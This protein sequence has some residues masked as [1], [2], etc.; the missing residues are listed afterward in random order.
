MLVYDTRVGGRG[1]CSCLPD[2]V[3]EGQELST[4]TRDGAR[5]RMWVEA[6]GGAR[7]VRKVVGVMWGL[8]R[9]GVGTLT[10]Q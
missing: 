7:A 4:F 3:D 9:S 1:S 8:I 2:L 10:P 6:R 5:L